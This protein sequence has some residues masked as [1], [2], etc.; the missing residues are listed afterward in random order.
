M[1]LFELTLKEAIEGIKDK[2]YRG[3][4]IRQEV[5]N[6]LLKVN[7]QVHAF[8]RY[9]E[10]ADLEGETETGLYGLPICLKDNIL[11]KEFITTA[12]SRILENFLPPYESTVSRR[13]LENNAFIE[14]K[15]NLDA[16]AHGSSTET[17]DFGPTLNPWDLSKLPG[18]SSGGSAAAVA[19][20]LCLA[21]IGTETAGSIRQPAGWCGVVGLKPTYG[22]VSRY[23]IVAMASSTDSP[24]PITKSVWDAAYLL[25]FLAGNDPFDATSLTDSVP[26]YTAGLTGPIKGLKIGVPKEYF[27]AGVSREVAESVMA[28]LKALESLGCELKEISLV[29]PKYAIAVYT[30]IQRAE[31]SSNL[32]RYDGVRFGRGRD[33][34]GNEAERRIM[35]GTYTLSAGYYEAYYKKAE[36]VRTLIIKDF[37][38]TFGKVDLIAGPVSPNVAL[39]VGS[40]LDQAMFGEMADALLE[41]SSIAGLPGIS[42]PCGF[43]KGLPVGLNIIGPRLS[44]E[45]ILRVA[46]QY[47]QS[48]EWHKLKPKI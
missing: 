32:G 18:G 2:K 23:G 3:K 4:E 45:L 34:F 25:N 5:L 14:G 40:T 17:S 29:D 48:T 6:R 27:G 12:S 39:P 42:V 16:W 1:K 30:V 36:R 9:R 38:Q 33:S 46:Y 44:E 24:G 47:E 15:T 37:D 8:L 10:S 21:A 11:T 28:A 26:D 20:D 41:P 35:L 43:V 19:A 13:L 22:R 31:V 7:P